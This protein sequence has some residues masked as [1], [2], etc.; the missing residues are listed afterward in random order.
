MVKNYSLFIFLFCCT[1]TFGYG[2]CLSDNFNSGYGN[3]SD[4]GTYQNVIAG[5]TGNGTGFNSTVDNIITNSVLTNPQVLTLWLSRSGSTENKTLS[6]QYSV[7]NAG[8]WT[9]A[10]DFL[11]SDATTTH[12]EFTVILNL[13][14]DYYIRIIMSQRTGGSYYLD[15]IEVNCGAS[16]QEIQIQGNGTEIVDGSTTPNIGDDTD[17]GATAITG[18]TV[19][20]TFTISNTGGADLI[21][22]GTAPNYVTV[23]PST[24]FTITQPTLT[25]IPHT[26]GNFTTFQIT[27]D[28]NGLGTQTATVSVDN[29][30][31]DEDPYDFIIE[32]IGR[33]SNASDIIASSMYTYNSNIDYLTYQSA[34]ITNTTQSIDVLRVDIRDG[35]ASNDTDSQTTE[36]TDIVFNVTNLANIRTAALFNANT[37]IAN[38]PSIGA[39]TISFSGLSYPAADD[40]VAALTLRV[41]FLTTVTDNDQLEFTISSASANPS[42][43]IFNSTDA[44]GA[45]SSILN[46]RNR[47]EVVAD[48]LNFLQQPSN[49]NTNAIMFA[50]VQVETMDVN[51]N[52]DLDWTGNINISSSGSM[53]GDPITE[54]SVNSISSFSNIIH[55]V[56]GTNLNLSASATGLISVTSSNFD[57]TLFVFSTGD[58]RPKLGTDLSFN[59]DWDYFDGTVWINAP[60][61]DA[62]Q[63]TSVTI[64]RILI[65]DYVTGGASSSTNYDCDILILA[66]GI[67]E[68]VDKSNS[69]VAEFLSANNTLEIRDNG[70][71][72]IRGDI[73]L[74]SSTNLFMRSGGRMVIDQ[75]SMNNQH[76]IWD[77]VEKF[78]GGSMLEI[79]DW[80]W[81]ITAESSSL[82]N[83]TTAI[84]DNDNGYKFGHVYFNPTN[85][86]SEWTIVGGPINVNVTENDFEINNT[87]TFFV[88][89]MSNNTAGISSTYNGDFT[90]SDGN[91][92]FG[93]S[94]TND[95]FEQNILIRGDVTI[96]S[97]D[98]FYIHH[99]FNGSATI[100]AETAPVVIEGNLEIWELANT[101][102]SDVTTKEILFSG[103]NTH[104]IEVAP[105]CSNV[106]FIIEA[107]DT[108]VLSNENLKFTG[109]SSIEIESNAIFNFSFNGTAALEVQNVSG[110][111]NR[112][113]Q[114]SGSYLYITHSQ[115]I[116]DASNN[117]NVQGFAATNTSYNQINSTYHFIG[118]SNQETG[119]AFSSNSN[120]K[121]IICELDTNSDELTATIRTG[122]S[123]LL[124][125]RRGILVNTDT[126]HIFGSGD[127]NISDGGLRSSVVTATNVVPVLTGTYNLTDGFVQLNATTDQVLRGSRAYR[128]L[129]FS[130]S[131]TKTLSSSPTSI[132]GTILVEDIAILNVEANTMGGSN[133][134]LTMTDASEY[135]TDG[136]GVKPDALETYNLG[137]GTKITYVNDN[138]TLQGIRL[139][140]DYYNIDVVGSNVGTSSTAL[141]IRIQS[142]GTFTVKPTGTFKFIN[143]AGFNG[144][145][146]TS[147]DNTNS[148]SIIL[149]TGSTI[150][151]AGDTQTLTEF[152]PNYSNVNIS[153]TDRKAMG[154]NTGIIIG[155]NLDVISS[156]LYID[157]SKFI[158]VED[159][160]TIRGTTGFIG[161][162]R[163][164]TQ[165]SFVQVG[166]SGTFSLIGIGASTTNKLSAPKETWLDYT[167]W[168]SPITSANIDV[169]FAAMPVD[170]KYEY[171]AANYYDQYMEN[172][173]DNNQ[174]TL[175][176]DDIDDAAPYD[177]QVVSGTMTPGHGYAIT[178]SPLAPG[179][180]YVESIDFTG[181]FN[182]GDIN[183][184]I[185]INTLAAD[186]D[187]NFIG[188]PYPSAIDFTAF[189]NQNSSIIEGCAFLWSHATLPDETN[190]GNQASNF[191]QDD[192]AI[193]TVGSG[194][195]AGASTIIPQPYIPSG[196]G[197]FVVGQSTNIATFK[198]SMRIADGI[199]NNQFFRNVEPTIEANKIWINLRSDNGIFNQALI[200]YIDGATD[201]FDSY[202]YD[203]PR[204]LSSRNASI[205]Y[206]KIADRADKKFA[207]Q[208]K[209]P[210]SLALNEVIPLGFYTSIDEVTIYTL[211]IAQLEGEF[212]TSN[213][214]YIIDRLNNVIHDLSASDY[215]FTSEIG[216]FNNR[217]EIVFRA[218]A[219]SIHTNQL[220]ENDLTII[221]LSN[222]DVQFKIGKNFT[223]TNVEILDLTG[224]QIYNYKGHNST[225]AYDLSQLSKAPYIGKVTLSNGQVISKKAIKRL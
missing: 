19:T 33:N 134:F 7:S 44:G 103:N 124:D 32:G 67:L 199:S 58:F 29:N 59:G 39:G 215:T 159:N 130:T 36:L 113:L 107:G 118:N 46:N 137:A 116:W 170:R 34:T 69:P 98:D 127:L 79:N 140:R 31:S 61:N 83:V 153:G 53:T 175:G 51:T 148:P 177:W 96:N 126:N 129:I 37:L 222:G 158:Q 123:E 18:S 105:N 211:S 24:E 187:W 102:T 183:T 120:S 181:Q 169:L 92:T 133:T 45:I 62:P 71:L 54:P 77:G 56:A 93:G 217:F 86:T 186:N 89:G 135:I 8:P 145:N 30:D 101:V 100:V 65:D 17:F 157:N 182:T 63:N 6:I 94:F 25:T 162:I 149:E 3:W 109:N 173:N 121:T 151:Y 117:G 52:K 104:T 209:D 76:P 224:R 205:I 202:S 150:E 14:G 125:I 219:L 40:G 114:R 139:F 223:I 189:H 110:G 176:Q 64:N 70:E 115:G 4:S 168:S 81:T 203:A 80:D 128:D 201:N 160:T 122:T 13:T 10:R 88:L 57:I 172:L 210:N 180:P 206:T 167:Y 204:N 74:S 73:D 194:C 119:D 155:E 35:G 23:I 185:V 138:I 195:T 213:S 48:R 97:N 192:Y 184:P 42:G 208:G 111:N 41:T 164:E 165:G 198:N 9:S 26:V 141:P 87:S 163:V 91:F 218:D 220:D 152:L 197:F 154:T 84:D 142:G 15:D 144:S 21:L 78:E 47:I 191:S 193:I 20:K 22:D 75:N 66:G 188:N 50:N 178:G 43:S 28:P 147:I 156:E 166:D 146:L 214:I 72:L 207:I 49:T 225:E 60:S 132:T 112:F 2:Q 190:N 131:G 16:S 106:P 95:T 55:T 38:N 161:S 179:F 216:E 90:V 221:E 82:I 85:L 174:T 5:R 196:Q 171:I 12:Q 212:L 108:A 68:I 99:E 11:V 27:F 1:L 136:V 200:A 143:T